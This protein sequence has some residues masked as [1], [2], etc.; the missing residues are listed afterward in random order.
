MSERSASLKLNLLGNLLKLLNIF[1]DFLKIFLSKK[2]KPLQLLKI[3]LCLFTKIIF[4]KKQNNAMKKDL[5]KLFLKN[6]VAVK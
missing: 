1:S 2:E 4:L 6:F 3:A 5:F